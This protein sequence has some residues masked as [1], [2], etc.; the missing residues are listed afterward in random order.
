MKTSKKT[1]CILCG[2]DSSFSVLARKDQIRWSC[3]G[4]DKKVIQ[5]N[6][7]GLA[8]LNPTWTDKE[9]NSLYK[10]YLRHREDFP[11]Q[12][13]KGFVAEYV[14]DHLRKEDRILEVGC[15]FGTTLHFFEELGYNIVGIDLDKSYCDDKSIFHCDFK[16]FKTKVD[17]IYALQVMEHM[18]DPFAFMKKVMSTLL[19]KGRFFLEIPNLEDPLL[20]I[21]KNKK[22]KLFFYYPYHTFFYLPKTIEQIVKQFTSKF[23]VKR[24]QRY[25]L[26]NHL[27]WIIK[28]KPGNY[29][30]HIPILD[31][32][33]KFFLVYIL[34]VS[35][36][37]V[38]TGEKDGM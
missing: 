6:K 32:I 23:S 28:G 10:E 5:C 25:G 12:I 22:F 18:K 1:N 2:N 14:W 29:N 19:P 15:G 13:R 3:F 34:K 36:T 17:F 4:Y 7:C 31:D 35:D 11:G 37:M 38:I 27:R 20:T 9:I 16:N 26:W 21:F 33:Y 8:F 30:P 24:T